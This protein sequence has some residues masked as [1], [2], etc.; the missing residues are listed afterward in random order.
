MEKVSVHGGHSGQFCQHASDSLEEV[1]KAYIGQGFSWVGITEHMPP[2]SDEFRYGDE[3]EA[4]ISADFLQQRFQ[5]YFQECRSLQQ[6]YV[7]QIEI[8]TAFETE[9]YEGS[10]EFV[11]EL[12]RS[13]QPDYIVGSVHHVG[14][15]GIDFNEALYRQALEQSGSVE[16]LYCDYLD[17]Q[18]Q[19]LVALKPSVVGHFDLIR[20]FD[21]DYSKT[22]QAEEVQQRINRNLAFMKQEEL[23][24]DFNLR[25]YYKG[26]EAYPCP[27]I[28]SRAVELGVAVAPG[29]DSHGVSSVGRNYEAGIAVLKAAGLSEPWPRPR[30]LQ[31]QP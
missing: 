23:I 31:Y 22:L 8:F 14:G 12:I 10:A 16:A 7:G 27:Q 5:N 25:G 1:I 2:I 30:L 13:T 3:V 29:D 6:K 19:M 21:P 11:Q 24:M 28:L 15:I 18:F 4:G 20:I 17:A 9:T 26:T